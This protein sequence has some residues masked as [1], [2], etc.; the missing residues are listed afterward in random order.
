MAAI[1]SSWRF[2]PAQRDVSARGRVLAPVKVRRYG[3]CHGVF[4]AGT[5]Q[6]CIDRVRDAGGIVYSVAVWHA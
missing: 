6:E 3:R 2:R 1:A 5:L 4:V